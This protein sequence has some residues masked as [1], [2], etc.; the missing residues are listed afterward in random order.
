[1]TTQNNLE[2]KGTILDHPLAEILA[3]IAQSGLNGSLKLSHGE[4]K[5]VIYCDGGDVIFAASNSRQDRLFHILLREE[6]ILPSELKKFPN[7]ANDIELKINLIKAGILT[8]KETNE[9]FAVQVRQ[10]LQDALEWDE[11]S[12][13]FSPLVRLKADIRVPLD[14]P[15]MLFSYGRKFRA[16]KIIKRFKS[17][18]GQFSVRREIP[19]HINLLPSEAFIFSRFD[20]G[21]KYSA[22]DIK[23]LGGLAEAE[24]L[25]TLYTLW[26]G[27]FLIRQRWRSAFSPESLSAIL[28]AK[29]ELKSKAFAPKPAPEKIVDTKKS[30]AEQLAEKTNDAK[31]EIAIEEYLEHIENALTY[32]EILDVSLEAAAPEIKSAYFGLAKRFHPDLFYRRVEDELHRRIQNAFTELAQAYEALRNTESREVYDFRLRKELA[33]LAKRS[34]TE[35]NAPQ[36]TAQMLEAQAAENFELGFD[37]VME[38]EYDE[39]IA[40]LARAVHLVG[41]NARY[42]AYYGRA[43]S[44]NKETY[45]QAEAELQAALRLEPDNLDYRLMLVNLFIKIGL[46][47]RAEGELGRILEKTPNNYEA[48]SL[49][50]SL[51]DK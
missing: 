29:F 21:A 12:W 2:V 48:R 38:E 22:E 44:V 45:R 32:Y 7:F 42:R 24:T 31:P 3:E 28:S 33:N 37:L 15:D 13:T 5:I 10:I 19:I 6:K 43:L 41:G 35:K 25:K 1:M 30:S 17:L 47:K 16:E 20:S 18:E 9:L 8:E 34:Q 46:N 23:N 11:G 36:S 51:L 49:L 40:Y 26:L 39:A 27:G 50:D 4:Q 14:L